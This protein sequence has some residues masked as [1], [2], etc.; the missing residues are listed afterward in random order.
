MMEY[1]HQRLPILDI[2]IMKSNNKI[3]TDIYYI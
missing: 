3:E 1:I 2:L